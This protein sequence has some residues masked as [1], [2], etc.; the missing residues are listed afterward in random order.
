MSSVPLRSSHTRS[1]SKSP[2][3]AT[4]SPLST[5]PPSPLPTQTDLHIPAYYDPASGDYTLAHVNMLVIELVRSSDP[6]SG[7]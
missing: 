7:C 1:M 4:C 3:P 2:Q 5:V 6:A